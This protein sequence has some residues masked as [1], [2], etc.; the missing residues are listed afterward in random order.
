MCKDL[1]VKPEDF[2]VLVLA[3][4]FGADQMCRFTRE[5]FFQGMKE[6]KTDTL[7]GIQARL[8]DVAAEVMSD[9]AKFKDLYRYSFKF[10]LDSDVGQRILPADMAISLWRVVFSQKEPEI[11]NRWIDFLE[12][13]PHIRGIPR[14]TW[15]MFLNFVV[16]VGTDL[17]TYDDTEAWPSLFD[18]FVEYENDKLN[19]NTISVFNSN[20]TSDKIDQQH[21]SIQQVIENSYSANSTSSSTTL[22]Q[23]QLTNHQS[24]HQQ[25]NQTDVFN[26]PSSIPNQSPSNPRLSREFNL[27]FNSSGP[28]HTGS[29]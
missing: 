15:N 18:D 11:L 3:W 21:Y 13:H 10:A 27:N 8:P 25:Q 14:D 22:S 7:Q 5:E 1:E 24:T 28:G 26:N 20:S 2:K 17:S 16:T 19:Q 12:A 4:K 29:R 9:S 6:L 23:Y